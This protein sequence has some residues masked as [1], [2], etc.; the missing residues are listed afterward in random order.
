M[1]STATD[2]IATLDLIRGVAVMGIFSVNVIAFAMI[3]GAY[4]N[5]GAYGGHSGLDLW[6]WALNL[7]LVDGKMRSLF[8]M[9]FGASMLLVIDRA[10]AAGQNAAAVH[11]RRMIVLMGFGLLHFYFIW[12]GDI[13]FS[14]GAVGIIAFLFRN[15]SARQLAI[16]GGGLLLVSTIMFTL[17][18]FHMHSADL[19]AHAAGASA[20]TIAD[21]NGI[22]RLLYPLPSDFMHDLAVHRG[23]FFGRSEYMFTERGAEPF[24][25]LLGIGPETLGL[26]L[27]GMAGLKSGFL[28]G[29]WSD[30]SYRHLAWIAV[31]VGAIAFALLAFVDVRSHFY[32]PLVFGGFLALVP[33]RTGMALGYA[34]LI[35]LAGRGM[36]P[37]AGRIEAAGRCA[38]TNYLGT[39]LVA[40]FVFYGWGLGL[41][42]SVSRYHAWLLAPVVW[43]A[44]L[45]WSKPWLERFQYGPLEWL[46]RSLSRG[47]LQPMRK[48]PAPA[49]IA[50]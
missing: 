31:P 44:M 41:Y 10:E 20:E 46:W 36:G 25:S 14:Y 17:F 7:V 19:A 9:L 11:L 35:I 26:M 12:F 48:R 40:S 37:L 16:S 38:F 4:F 49:P 47:A 3:E 43:L 18:A 28:T 8:S 24:T 21:W 2:R 29:A 30:T 6:L 22:G 27:L 39:S 15:R 33:F 1:A 5:P 23:G 50:A 13:L 34:A 42:G 45:A 32:S